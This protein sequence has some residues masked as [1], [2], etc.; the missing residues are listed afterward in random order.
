MGRSNPPR[1]LMLLALA[2]LIALAAC[3]PQPAGELPTV[4]VLPTVDE[5]APE[6]QTV[7]D[8]SPTPE[9]T[10]NPTLVGLV[11]TASAQPPTPTA[12]A[13]TSATFTVTPSLTITDTPTL[14]A[15]PTAS[16]TYQITILDILAQ[17][18]AVQ[19]VLPPQ[20]IPSP[21]L[22]PGV[23]GAGGLPTLPPPIPGGSGG[24]VANPGTTCTETPAGGFGAAYFNDPSIPGLIG[25]PQPFSLAGGLAAAVQNFERGS[26]IWVQGPVSY[27]YVLFGGGTYQRYVDTWVDGETAPVGAAPPPGLTEPVRG[28]GKVWRENPAVRDGLGWAVG[29]ENG[30]TGVRQEF[31]R[32]TMLY[33]S[34][35]GDILLLVHPGD[36]AAGS[37]RGVA[38][39]F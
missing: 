36:G 31:Q 9:P 27:I 13:T 10:L 29:F 14:T 17:T 1:A 8:A 7:S 34:V 4:M 20:F 3:A 23:S 18:A 33:V 38:G 5:S 11:L 22:N 39:M 15:T 19:T 12:S 28:F 32:G 26:M 24:S 2:A 30:A 35:R 37:W 6:N 21:T 25:C 16:E